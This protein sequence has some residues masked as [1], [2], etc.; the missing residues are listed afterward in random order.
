MYNKITNVT[1]S[2]NYKLQITAFAIIPLLTGQPNFGVHCCSSINMLGV[3][4]GNYLFGMSEDLK[5]HNQNT[6]DT[7]SIMEIQFEVNNSV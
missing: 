2:N 4:T 5:E 3:C 6:P 7:I 1:F